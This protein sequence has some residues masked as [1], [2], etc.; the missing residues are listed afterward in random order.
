MKFFRK[1]LFKPNPQQGLTLVEALVAITVLIIGVIGPLNI[2]A[3]GIGDGI[4]ARNQIAA[5]YLAQE[6]LELVLNRR[7]AL[8]RQAQYLPPDSGSIFDNDPQIA[9]CVTFSNIGTQYCS[10][11]AQSA[12]N[13]IAANCATDSDNNCKL[14]YNNTNKLYDK[15]GSAGTVFY[16]LVKM[17][18]VGDS[19]QLEVKVI[20][21]WFNKTNQK[22][23][24]LVEYLFS[25]G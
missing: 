21:K 15:S 3:R 24:T 10:L 13:L 8:A 6:A 7:Y 18:Y 17:R 4:F 2:A 19:N 22:T 5:N 14:V 1:N 12:T 9:G 20:V 25:N 23:L 11:D 16:R